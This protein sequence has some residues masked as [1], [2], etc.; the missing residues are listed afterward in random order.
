M[1]EN[2]SPFLTTSERIVIKF[3]MQW[4]GESS[5]NRT[6]EEYIAVA[7]KVPKLVAV[8]AY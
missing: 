5:V 1:D 7:K 6:L 2:M 4:L 8:H 3:L